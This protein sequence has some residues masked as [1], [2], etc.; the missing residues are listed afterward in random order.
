MTDKTKNILKT[1]TVALAFITICVGVFF[2]SY[3]YFRRNS[4]SQYE[5]TMS[6]EINK[7]TETNKNIISYIDGDSINQEKFL[8]LLPN[9]INTLKDVR[10]NIKSISK[11]KRYSISHNNLLSGLDNNILLFEEILFI[12]KD[13]EKMDMNISISRLQ[14][15]RDDT[16]NY[17]SQVFIGTSR[18]SIDDNFFKLLSTPSYFSNSLDSNKNI[19]DISLS[20]NLDFLDL[21][22]SF[23]RQFDDLNKTYSTNIEGARNEL[24]SYTSVISLINDDLVSLTSLESEITFISIPQD[25]LAVY[26]SMLKV[27]SSYKP[28][29]NNLKFAIS[30]EELVTTDND[31][32]D[33][34]LDNYYKTSNSNYK[35]ATESHKKFIEA[36]EKFESSVQK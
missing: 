31:I 11:N 12:V 36:F 18:I 27:I 6:T 30:N 34:I 13:I 23:S 19:T 10:S 2:V 20:D 24:Q 16:M 3:S 32:S 8:T 5:K 9:D 35:T 21:I 15:F 7:I 14:N 28:Y 26:E 17:Y 33:D 22:Y 4:L 1:I 25:G 29:L